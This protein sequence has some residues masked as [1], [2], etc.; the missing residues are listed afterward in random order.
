MPVPQTPLLSELTAALVRAVAAIET[1]ADLSRQEVEHVINDAR[2]IL[3]RVEVEGGDRPDIAAALLQLHGA[4][5]P[6]YRKAGFVHLPMDRAL[7]Q[8][9]SVLKQVYPDFEADSAPPIPA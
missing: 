3:D 6:V 5:E 9:A 7:K 4:A 1:P 2:A 8:A